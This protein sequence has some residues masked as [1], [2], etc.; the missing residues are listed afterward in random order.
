MYIPLLLS[1]LQS[2]LPNKPKQY[3]LTAFKTF[4]SLLQLTTTTTTTSW[5]KNLI[6][7]VASIANL[8]DSGVLIGRWGDGGVSRSGQKLVAGPRVVFRSPQQ[9]HEFGYPF[10][11]GT[12]KIQKMKNV[13]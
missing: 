5:Y 2:Q 12:L 13:V 10:Q 4:L 9:E 8:G 3:I 1:S 11:L 7:G 6:P